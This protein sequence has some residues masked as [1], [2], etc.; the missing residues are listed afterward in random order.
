MADLEKVINGLECAI[1][2]D[3]YGFK[4]CHSCVYRKDIDHFQYVCDGDR[5]IMDALALLKA[6]EP[7]T[8]ETSD[9]YHT[10]NELYHHRAVLFSVIVNNY[11][12]LAWKSVRHHDGT[13][14]DGMFI[15]GIDTPDGQATYH[16]DINPYWD[17]FKCRVREFAPE[18]DG[19]TSAQAIERIGKLKAQEPPTVREC[20]DL[21]VLRD[22][23]SGKVLKSGC[24]DY[25]IYNG[26]WYRTHKWDAP[27]EPRVMTLEE[28]KQHNNQDGCVWFEQPT[29]NA[30]AAFVR[31]ED[32]EIEVIS[33][34]ILGEPINHGYWINSNYGKTWRCW[35]SRPTP[36]QMEAT[37][38]E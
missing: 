7:I 16:Y 24:K 6:Q 2:P 28:V 1:D 17:M 23:K 26:D 5:C 37:P 22:I 10:F 33:P 9:G 38:W 8:G 27:H 34:Y 25:V 31:K 4:N 36:E 35:T 13:M 11:K 21:Q 15:V 14:Y 19:H 3:H 12:D 18:W 32:F 30:V 20:K 29:Y